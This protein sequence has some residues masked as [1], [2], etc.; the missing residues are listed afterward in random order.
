MS[1]KSDVLASIDHMPD[2]ASYMDLQYNLYV[3]NKISLGEASIKKNSGIPHAEVAKR[4][5]KWLIK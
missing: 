2:K 4:L 5:K 3:L 1:L